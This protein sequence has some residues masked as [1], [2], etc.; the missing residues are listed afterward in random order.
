MYF[1]LLFHYLT[2]EVDFSIALL[3]NRVVLVE[4]KIC[5]EE[6]HDDIL[7]AMFTIL[8]MTAHSYVS[9][10]WFHCHCLVNSICW[11]KHVLSS[12]V[13]TDGHTVLFCLQDRTENN[14]TRVVGKFPVNHFVTHFRTCDRMKYVIPRYVYGPNEDTVELPSN[15]PQHFIDLYC[16][17]LGRQ[18]PKNSQ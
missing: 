7:Q 8:V 6:S 15:K 11:C 4:L 10:L 12:N 5:N 3:P 14:P 2:Y 16:S 17:G 1:N 18:K 9:A 13:C